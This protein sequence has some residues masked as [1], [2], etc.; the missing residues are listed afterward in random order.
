MAAFKAGAP[1]VIEIPVAE[2]FPAPARG[3]GASIS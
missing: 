1:A 2:Y 3:P